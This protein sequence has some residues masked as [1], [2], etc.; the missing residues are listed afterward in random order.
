MLGTRADGTTGGG[1]VQGGRNGHGGETD[2]LPDKD[3]LEDGKHGPLTSYLGK[4]CDGPGPRGLLTDNLPAWPTS[5]L[6]M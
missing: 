1:A 2:A 3:N 5:T 4:L 6:W